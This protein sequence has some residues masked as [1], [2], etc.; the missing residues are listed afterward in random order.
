MKLALLILL[1]SL[2]NLVGDFIK[3]PLSDFVKIISTENNATVLINDEIKKDFTL[4]IN[5]SINKQTYS[6]I[7]NDILDQ[8]NLSFIKKNNYY[9]IIKKDTIKNTVRSIQLKYLTFEDLKEF[10]T[11]FNNIKFKYIKNTKTLFFRSSIDDYNLISNYIRFNDKL[12][13]QYKLKITI[14]E[15]NINKLKQLGSE[16]IYNNLV[17]SSANIFYNLIAYPF[18]AVT[19]IPTTETNRDNL[20]IMLKYLNSN[21]V[22]SFLTT[23][24]IN[25]FDNKQTSLKTVQNIPY[26]TSTTVYDED[27]TKQTTSTK[28]RDVGLQID[29]MPKIYNNHVYLDIN[30]I[31]ETLISS[32]DNKT[33]ITS[34]IQLKK[35]IKLD[36]GSIFFLTG[37]NQDQNFDNTDNIPFLS[38]LPILGFLFSNKE[39]NYKNNNLTII[40][41]LINDVDSTNFKNYDN[42]LKKINQKYKSNRDINSIINTND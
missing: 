11:L 26:E 27:K 36:N 23:P 21:G 18:N 25:I 32:I 6:L 41:E 28:Y 4:I 22:T 39:Q 33:P 24:I 30:L 5:D 35:Y 37:L 8:N 9:T 31:N 3:F 29:I 15:T 20:N 12:P 1:L 13:K 34:K 19:S 17:P 10:F 14:L 2:T 42:V 40:L 16:F 7:F 38:D